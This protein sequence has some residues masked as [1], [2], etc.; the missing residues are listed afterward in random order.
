MKP[1]RLTGIHGGEV[2]VNPD[3][4]SVVIQASV[5]GQDG[6]KPAHAVI[7]NPN[8]GQTQVKET[9]EEIFEKLSESF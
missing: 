4:V 1:I 3:F 8:G 2:L 7:I 9:T 5:S 6:E